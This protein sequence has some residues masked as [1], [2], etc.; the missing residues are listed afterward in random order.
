MNRLKTAWRIIKKSFLAFLAERVFKLSAALSYYTLFSLPGLVII[1]IWLG[2]IF[3]G[4]AAIEGSVYGEIADLVGRQA[5]VQIQDTIKNATLSTGN[6]LTTIIGVITLIIGA[7]S[8]F[9]E[10]QDS[11][12]LI[13]RLKAKPRKGWVKLLVNRL[14]SFS[15]IITLG[16]LLLVSLIANGLMDAF[17]HR[18][19]IL[20]PQT[21]VAAV[22]IANVVLTFVI[23][24]FLFGIIF[25]VLP[26]AKIQWC[27][28]RVGAFT[29]ALLFMG[30]KFLISYYLGRS[31]M[32]SAYGA[33]GSVIVIL[34]WVYYSALILYFGAIFTRVYAIETGS[35]IY[36]DK[37]AVWVKEVEIESEKSIQK[38]PEA[39][40][41]VK[42]V[43]DQNMDKPL[44][45]DI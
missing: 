4:R 7:T 6:K 22:Y 35:H 42:S 26:D 10:I 14:L 12:N 2:D 33:A 13:W 19:T 44:Q 15:I 39:K 34:L 11:I 21:E 40:K 16:F 45:P 29:T 36:P 43:D 18:L 30:G 24:S 3:Y 17:I 32:T 20:F 9:G 28:V 1:V 31:S 27:N 37:Y 41:I 25:K 23:T 38:Q 8:V 5:A